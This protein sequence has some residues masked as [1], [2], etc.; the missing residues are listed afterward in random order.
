MEFQDLLE[1]K[2]LI[3]GTIEG[4]QEGVQYRGDISKIEIRGE[5]LLLTMPW[6][7]VKGIGPLRKEY[8]QVL[9]ID[10]TAENV[11]IQLQNTGMVIIT[12]QPDF[13]ILQ[14]KT[15]KK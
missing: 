10:T 6:A 2:D 12:H 11:E 8:N 14:P 7:Y 1:R 9:A 4:E 5:Q 3:G 13:W 15:D